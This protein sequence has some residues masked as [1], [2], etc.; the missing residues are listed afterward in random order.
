MCI[1][2]RW[3]WKCA[4]IGVQLE[5]SQQTHGVSGQGIWTNIAE[6]W[7]EFLCM[8]IFCRVKYM[9][10][11][12]FHWL[13]FNSAC[14]LYNCNLLCRDDARGYCLF[15]IQKRECNLP[16][17]GAC[18]TIHVFIWSNAHFCVYWQ[19]IPRARMLNKFI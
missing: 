12:I 2:R 5:I 6:S 15:T 13:V 17:F 19:I 3:D 4:R 8:A 1:F 16:H 7:I 10:E 9:H 11:N 18:Y 14:T